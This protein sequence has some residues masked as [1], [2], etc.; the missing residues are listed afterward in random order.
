MNLNEIPVPTSG[1][2]DANGVHH[3][4]V[5]VYYEDTDASGIVYYANYLRFIERGRTD[6][7]RLLG[8]THSSVKKRDQI[9]FVVRQCNIKYLQP[10]RLDDELVVQTVLTRLRGS[11]MELE[12]RVVRGRSKVALAFI[13][14]ACID[15]EGALC[16]L[17]SEAREALKL[18]VRKNNLSV[19]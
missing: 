3:L 6:L 10:A 1:Q 7:L 4:G 16:R 13:R 14:V 9:S 12:Q 19:I 15:S 18:S 5:R 11:I 8:V 17:S 2:M